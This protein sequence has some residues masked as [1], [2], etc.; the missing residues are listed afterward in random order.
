MLNVPA[1]AAV[2]G[3][4]LR[5]FEFESKLMKLGSGLSSESVTV[6][7]TGQAEGVCGL[8]LSVLVTGFAF[9]VYAA[10]KPA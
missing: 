10:G 4:M 5:S 1:W 3:V 6:I 7:T 9:T 2:V 8:R